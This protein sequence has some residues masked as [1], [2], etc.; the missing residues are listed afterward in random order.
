V[1]ATIFRGLASVKSRRDRKLTAHW[2]LAVN[3]ED[4]V[5]NLSYCPWSKVSITFSRV[6]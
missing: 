6:D 4:A 2:V 5:S 3:A 1:V